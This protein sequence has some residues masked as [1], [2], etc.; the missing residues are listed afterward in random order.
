M[1]ALVGRKRRLSED[2]DMQ[3]AQPTMPTQR[4]LP[5]RHYR[6]GRE[7]YRVNEVKRSKTGIQRDSGL[8]HMLGMT[9]HSTTSTLLLIS[10]LYSI[11]GQRQAYPHCSFFIRQPSRAAARYHV[12][13]PSTNCSISD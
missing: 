11:L 13:Y 10:I 1:L 12:V 2:E 4:S 9:T 7:A 5:E 8:T 3:D 6:N